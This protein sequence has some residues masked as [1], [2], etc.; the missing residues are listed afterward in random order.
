MGSGAAT[1]RRSDELSLD[2]V[3]VRRSRRRRALQCLRQLP[4]VMRRPDQADYRRVLPRL[5][6]RFEFRSN[7]EAHQPVIQAIQPPRAARHVLDHRPLF[8]HKVG[9]VERGFAAN[10]VAQHR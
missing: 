7:N 6:D 3:D 4:Y 2:G 9:R 8:T 5:L 10:T 1:R